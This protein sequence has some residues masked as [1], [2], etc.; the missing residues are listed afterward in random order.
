LTIFKTYLYE[1][2]VE[3]EIRDCYINN[4]FDEFDEEK[5]KYDSNILRKKGLNKR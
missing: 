5:V 1:A 4:F 3:K 2:T